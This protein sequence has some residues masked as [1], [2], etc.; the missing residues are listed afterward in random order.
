MAADADG[1]GHSHTDSANK[2]ILDEDSPEYQELLAE[3]EKL[4]EDHNFFAGLQV[5][6][7][8]KWGGKEIDENSDPKQKISTLRV[9]I[10][11]LEALHREP[12]PQ[13]GDIAELSE[14]L[15]TLFLE[16]E[17]ISYFSIVKISPRR[18]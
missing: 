14:A 18:H 12:E 2:Q 6:W 3:T 15:G 10:S 7:G 17:E 9:A 16:G 5:L 11:M 4:V 13:L 8:M 1:S